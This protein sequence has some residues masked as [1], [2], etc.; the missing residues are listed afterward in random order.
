MKVAYWSPIISRG[1]AQ[2]A[3][4]LA[5]IKSCHTDSHAHGSALVAMNTG[6]TLIGRP[7]LGSWCLYGLGT[8]NQSLPGYVVILGQTRRTDRRATELVERFY[9][10]DLSGD[11]VPSGGRSDFGLKRPQYIA[12]GRSISCGLDQLQQASIWQPDRV[13]HELAA[14]ESVRMNWH[15]GCSPKAPEAVDLASGNA[16]NAGHVRRRQQPTEEFGRNCLIARRLVERGVR[17][18]QLYSGGGHLED[19]WDAA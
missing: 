9:V 15:S 1:F 13:V 3:D 16:R 6:S 2:H 19:T 12:R 17:F 11:A 5:V 7:S 8:E 18:V 4:K 10:G 14:R